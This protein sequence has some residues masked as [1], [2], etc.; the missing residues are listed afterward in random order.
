MRIVDV[1]LR[2][3]KSDYPVRSI[4]RAALLGLAAIRIDET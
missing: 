1:S 4:D 3:I 2:L